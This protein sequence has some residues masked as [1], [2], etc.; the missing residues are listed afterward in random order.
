MY[1]IEEVDALSRIGQLEIN[2]KK[3]ITPNLIPVVH[4]FDQI[5]QPPELK[6]FGANAIFTNSFIMYQNQKFRDKIISQNIHRFL[7]YDGLIATDSGAFQQYMYDNSIP[8]DPKKIEAFQEDIG[9]DMPVILDLPVQIEDDYEKAKS[10]VL[11]TIKRAKDNIKRRRNQKCHWFGPIH[12]GIHKDLLRLSAEKMGELQFDIW[13]LGGL[14]KS[15]L[16]YRFN[17]ILEMLLTVKQYIP[18]NK[19]LHMFGLGLPQFF[20]LAVACGCDLMDSAA[21]ILFAKEDRYFTI[22]TGTKK[23]DNLKEF[24]CSCPI[25]CEYTPKQLKKMPEDIKTKL[26]AKHNLYVS[27]SELRKV[28]QAIREGNLWELVEQR[29]RNHPE[30]VNAFRIVKEYL[31]LFEKHEPI[32]K[33]H[34]RFY[35]T[36]ESLSRPLNYRYSQRLKDM[37]RAP[38]RARFLLII[39][40]LDLKAGNSLSIKRWLKQL[41]HNQICPRPLIHV[42]FLSN[43]F[44]LIPLELAQTFP[45]GQYESV[46]H[47]IKNDYHIFNTREKIKKFL[48]THSNNYQKCGLFLPK[49]YINE[50]DEVVTFDKHLIGATKETFNKFF[51]NDLFTSNNLEEILN[52][53]NNGG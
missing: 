26:L 49:T 32:Y 44:G 1:E 8:I 53:F 17:A 46:K 39:P 41:D 37:Y 10:K 12:G 36:F 48:N 13:A 51:E 47:I 33:N 18:S 2:G 35:T 14:V 7:E 45:M 50:Y 30:L 40:E 22:S 28:R 9:S 20:S 27:F 31:P 5:I 11:T 38:N 29:I 6:E 16:K 42:S 19:P 25:C 24:P 23:L 34:G 43:V 4:P 3:L 15:F 52:F 21:Y